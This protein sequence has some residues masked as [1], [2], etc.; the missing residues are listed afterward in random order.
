MSL[1]VHHEVDKTTEYEALLSRV[2]SGSHMTNAEL[3][4][5]YRLARKTGMTLDDISRL[6]RQHLR[7]VGQHSAAA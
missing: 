4:C 7:A 3:C 5:F 1:T 6:V 2:Q